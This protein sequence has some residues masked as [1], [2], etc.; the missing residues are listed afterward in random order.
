MHYEYAP[1]RQTIN[2][3]YSL[4]VCDIVMTRAEKDRK[5]RWRKTGNFTMIMLQRILPSPSLHSQSYSFYSLNL[6][7]CDF[8]LFLENNHKNKRLRVEKGNYEKKDLRALQHSGLGIPELFP[9]VAVPL[10][11]VFALSRGVL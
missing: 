6:T 5:C 7:T 8:W 2:K 1:A 3:E 4:K 9:A 10:G 11:E